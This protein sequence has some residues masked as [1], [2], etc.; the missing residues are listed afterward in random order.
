MSYSLTLPRLLTITYKLTSKNMVWMMV[1]EMIRL[2]FGKSSDGPSEFVQPKKPVWSSA[3]FIANDLDDG[4]GNM[5]I[6]FVDEHEAGKD[7]KRA[8]GQH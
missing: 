5:L 8:G 3:Q 1:R 4:R 6:T 2:F 7:K